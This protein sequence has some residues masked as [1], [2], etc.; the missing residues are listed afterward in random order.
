M[1]LAIAARGAEAEAGESFAEIL[2]KGF[3]IVDVGIDF[4]MVAGGYGF[5]FVQLK[6]AS[7][8]L[9]NRRL[10]GPHLVRERVDE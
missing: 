5:H 8:F 3:G 1:L 10:N 4:G 9:D 6:F 7:N 2:N